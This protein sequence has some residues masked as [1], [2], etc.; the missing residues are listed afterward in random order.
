MRR[1]SS[2]WPGHCGREPKWREPGSRKT[3]MLRACA[4]VESG[5]T[6]EGVNGTGEGRGGNGSEQEADFCFVTRFRVTV[7]SVDP[8]TWTQ[9]SFRHSHPGLRTV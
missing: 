3:L 5:W 9:S 6:W 2:P 8:S 7:T 1:F 4:K